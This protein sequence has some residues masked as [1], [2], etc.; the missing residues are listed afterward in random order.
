MKVSNK[1]KPKGT[2][3]YGNKAWMSHQ[4]SSPAQTLGP[5]V[6]IP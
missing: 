3:I 4:L 5:W 2:I 1:G 6:R